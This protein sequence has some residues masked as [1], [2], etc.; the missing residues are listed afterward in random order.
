MER[1]SQKQSD[2]IL[3]LKILTEIRNALDVLIICVIFQAAYLRTEDYFYVV[4]MLVLFIGYAFIR[5]K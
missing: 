1:D 2:Q 4:I 3:I 5:R